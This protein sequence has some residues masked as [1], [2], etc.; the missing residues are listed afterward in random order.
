MWSA[1]SREFPIDRHT[2]YEYLTCC[3]LSFQNTT[4]KTTKDYTE[5]L[6]TVLKHKVVLVNVKMDNLY[7]DDFF[8]NLEL[9]IFL[10]T[11][12]KGRFEKFCFYL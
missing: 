12:G 3:I 2:S 6:A 10:G 11:K 7:M 8:Q 4:V 5:V 9:V 1:F